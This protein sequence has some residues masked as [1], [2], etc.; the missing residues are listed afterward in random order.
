MGVSGVEVFKHPWELGA[1]QAKELLFTGERITADRAREL[2][3]VNRVVPREEL[4]E[5]TSALAETIAEMPRFGLALA[6]KAV[7]ATQGAMGQRAA[8]D[9]AFALHQLA[10]VQNE[11]ETGSRTA[12]KKVSD[13]KRVTGRDSG[14]GG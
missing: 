10:H 11:L 7:N 1:R 12:S 13:V 6:K 3:M 8:L 2:G 5:A 14:G 4:R 9:S